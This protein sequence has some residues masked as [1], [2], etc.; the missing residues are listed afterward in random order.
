MLANLE[1]AAVVIGL[2]KVTFLP[3][4]MLDSAK[5]FSNYCTFALISHASKDAQ[6]SPS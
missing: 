1:N 4:P 3:I 2:E 5:V 6:N